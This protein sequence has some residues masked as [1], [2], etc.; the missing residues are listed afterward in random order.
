V[1]RVGGKVERRQEEPLARIRS[2]RPET[3]SDSKFAALSYGARLLFIA[4]WNYADDYGCGRYLSK[5][6]GGFAFPHEDVDVGPWLKELE[7]SGRIIKYVVDSENFFT[8]PSW[9]R[10]QKPQNPGKRRIPAPPDPENE[11]YTDPNESLHTVSPESTP[12]DIGDRTED[13]GDGK[14]LRK[15]DDAF[16]AVLY[17]CGWDYDSLTKQAR[18]WINGALPELRRLDASYDEIVQRGRHYFLTYRQRPTPSA[19]V[20]HWP[21]LAEPPLR[22]SAKELDQAAS[23][24]RRRESRAKRT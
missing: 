11:C 15:R 7:E 19:L 16:A 1:R 6:I 24:Q 5:Q 9:D 13:I 4:L 10:H 23:K 12:L 14:S 21:A 2:V 17:V 18:G 8:I 22:I 20:K 3:W